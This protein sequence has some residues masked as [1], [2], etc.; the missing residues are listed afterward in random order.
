M[1]QEVIMPVLSDTMQTGRLVRWNKAVGDAVNKGDALAE[2]ETDKAILDVEAFQDGFLAGPLAPVDTDIPVRSVIAWLVDSREELDTASSSKTAAPGTGAQAANPAPPVPES[3]H[4]TA[5]HAAAQETVSTTTVAEPYPPHTVSDGVLASPYARALAQELGID[6]STL[7]TGPIDSPRVLAAALRG[8]LPDLSAGPNYQIE[9]LAEVRAAAARN[10]QSA[11]Q[12][13]AF[14]ISARLPISTL[15]AQAKAAKQS[16]TLVLA[17]A[18][19]LTVAEDPWF[20]HL[21]TPR[22]LAKRER[23]DVAIAVDTGDALLTPVLRDAARR[24]LKELAEDWRI[25]LGKIKRGR[26]APEDY[27]GGTFY[28][29]NLGVFDVVQSFDA[30]VPL[31]A[32]AILAVAATQAD[33]SGDCTLSCDHRVIFGADAARFLQRLRERIANPAWLDT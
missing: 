3:S 4:E 23:V 14:Q 21:W 16:F 18:C 9:R 22:G 20:N 32:A 24:P 10:M 8:P 26:L 2:V 29:S 33:G 31:G 6:L 7:G 5:P 12:T 17:R 19:A 15:Q 25:L 27:R 1:K 13:P 11:V 30:I 28:L